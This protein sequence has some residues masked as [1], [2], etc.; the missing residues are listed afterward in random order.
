MLTPGA[1]R[2]SSIAILDAFGLGGIRV[3]FANIRSCT[4]W[5]ALYLDAV[6]TIGDMSG[7]EIECHQMCTRQINHEAELIQWE[8]LNDE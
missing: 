7:R 3:M 1:P 8:A 4:G 6:I 2:A 5:R